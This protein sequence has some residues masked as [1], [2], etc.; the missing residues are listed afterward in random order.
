VCD[1]YDCCCTEDIDNP[2]SN[3]FKEECE[4]TLDYDPDPCCDVFV[5][6]KYGTITYQDTVRTEEQIK[7][8]AGKKIDVE[9]EGRK[10]EGAIHNVKLLKN[11]M[12]EIEF[13]VLDLPPGE[14]CPYS[15]DVKIETG[16]GVSN[17]PAT[18]SREAWIGKYPFPKGGS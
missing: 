6:F 1:R 14:L 12:V 16:S 15:E 4:F 18:L 17:N 5:P 2:R 8:L 7:E 10:Y 9:I 3:K 13:E 11:K